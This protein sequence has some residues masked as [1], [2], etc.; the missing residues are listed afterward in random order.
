MTI[1]SSFVFFCIVWI[2]LKLIYF[3]AFSL[4]AS[5]LKAQVCKE[6]NKDSQ[7]IEKYVLYLD[8]YA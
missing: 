1:V 3:S 6:K 8:H 5:D 4:Y 2:Y 7:N